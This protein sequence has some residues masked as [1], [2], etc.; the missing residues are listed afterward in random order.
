[1][2]GTAELIDNAQAKSADPLRLRRPHR[3]RG[4]IVVLGGALV[5][6][7]ILAAWWFVTETGLVPTSQMPSP[8]MVWVAL[9]DLVE[10][11]LL[12]LYIG[13]SAQRVFIGFLIGA[14]L[15][16]LIGAFVGLS[17]TFDILFSPTL[18]ALRAVPSL[19]WL[20]LL[21]L[22]LKLGEE[23]KITL[24]V[25][26]AFFPVYTVVASALRHVD[27]HLIEAGR[28]FGL[29]G[30]SLFTTVQLP[31]VIPETIAG[32]RLALAQA[33]LFLV[34]AELLGASMGLG[35]LLTDSTNTGRLDRTFLAIVLLAVIGK[36]SDVLVGLFERW[37]VR[38]WT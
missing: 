8:V 27:R 23:S 22:W 14:V 33:W 18:G 15:G 31:A 3:R 29:T 38:R 1:M 36:L 16:L 10:R 34:A 9:I 35:F 20:P 19:A 2:S 28:A 6:A 26:G 37:A 30:V 24:I 21:V 4:W 5:P 11:Q 12:W 13:I 17:R 25:I 32:L 7:L